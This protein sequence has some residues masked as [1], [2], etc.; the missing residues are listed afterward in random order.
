MDTIKRRALYASVVL[1]NSAL[2]MTL[3]GALVIMTR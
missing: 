2:W 1:L 3:A